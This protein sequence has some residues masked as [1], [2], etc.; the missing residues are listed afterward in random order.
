MARTVEVAVEALSASAF[1]PFGTIIGAGTGP[2]ALDW[3]TLQTWMAPFDVDGPTQMTLCRYHQEP[4]EWSQME[5]HLAVTQAFL[6]LGGVAS[7][8]VVAPPSD[9]ADRTALPP[10]DSVR[11]FHMDGSAGVVLRR[12]TWH[13]LRRF[14]VGSAANRHSSAHRT[15]H[16]GRT[17]APGA[18]RLPARADPRSRL[19]LGAWSDLSRGRFLALSPRGGPK[20]RL[21]GQAIR[22]LRPTLR[23][24]SL[25]GARQGEALVQARTKRHDAVTK[26]VS[27]ADCLRQSQV[28][29]FQGRVEVHRNAAS[30]DRRRQA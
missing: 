27:S 20:G 26:L 13:A 11:A 23:D 24:A 1:E 25:R 2:P 8:M 10:P 19:C 30:P 12:G 5:R 3:G 9:P 28:S 16:A 7:V 18:R 14:P 29:A 15:R 22:K 21:E 6:P 17:R 4:V